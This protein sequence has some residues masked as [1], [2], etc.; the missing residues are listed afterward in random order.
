METVTWEKL[1]KCDSCE[2]RDACGGDNPP[3]VILWD[4]FITW[5]CLGVF[6]IVFWVWVIFGVIRIIYWLK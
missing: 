3:K 6:A 5:I 2:M 1:M 4:V